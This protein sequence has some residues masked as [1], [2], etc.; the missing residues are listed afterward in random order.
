M[1]RN[2]VDSTFAA[3]FVQTFCRDD[4]IEQRSV[5]DVRKQKLSVRDNVELKD[6]ISL[7]QRS[8]N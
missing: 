1:D 3:L 2:L 5:M 6:S 7:R 8:S 4:L